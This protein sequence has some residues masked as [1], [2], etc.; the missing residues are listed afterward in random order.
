MANHETTWKAL[1]R[2]GFSV[3]ADVLPCGAGLAQCGLYVSR[4]CFEWHGTLVGS[5]GVVS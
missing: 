4:D 2:V 3:I 5:M 1:L